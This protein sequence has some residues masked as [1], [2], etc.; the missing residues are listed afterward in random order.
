MSERW[1]VLAACFT[2]GCRPVIGV[3]SDQ[4]VFVEGDCG[5]TAPTVTCPTSAYGNPIAFTSVDQL[6]EKVKG[7]WAFC[8]GERRYT[9]RE[10]LGGFYGGAG[11]EFWED[12]GQL[13]YVFLMGAPPYTQ[14]HGV[15]SEGT[16]RLELAPTPKAVLIAQDGREAPWQLELFDAQPVLRNSAFDVWDFV[17]VP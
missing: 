3:G 10:I 9:G 17:A 7:R 14:R 4:D 16:V 6:R 1:L 5:L 15:F 11:V 13:K 12:A 8:G 2:I